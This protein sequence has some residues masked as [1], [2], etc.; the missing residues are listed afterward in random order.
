MWAT[1]E[2]AKIGV[3]S[4]AFSFSL[5]LSLSLHPFCFSLSS[6]FTLKNASPTM[7]NQ[8]GKKY[9]NKINKKRKR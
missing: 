4:F 3:K 5:S 1:Y 6:L 9:K 2:C 8:C 7:N